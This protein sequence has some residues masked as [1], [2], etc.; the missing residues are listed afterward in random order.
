M[1]YNINLAN[2]SLLVT[3]EEGVADN[4][5]TSLTLLGKNYSGYG[6]SINENFV[7]LLENF[8][9]GT[10]PGGPLS[11]QIWY[12][13]TN[14][15]LKLWNG[16]EW[17]LAG[18][19]IQL[20]QQSSTLHYHAFVEQEYGAPPF[21]T[22]KNKGL[23]FQPSSGNFAINKSSIPAS[24]LEINGGTLTRGLPAPISVSAVG[25]T[26]VHIH[27]ADGMS[28]RTIIDSF[29]GTSNA[30]V[31]SV[32]HVRRSRGSSNVP[33]ALASSDIIGGIAS[34]GHNGSTYS[35]VSGA[36]LFVADAAWTPSSHPT[37]IDVILAPSNSTVA[38]KKFSFLPNGDFQAQG[39]VVAYNTS[40]ISLKT[41]IEPIT[42][43]F[44]KLTNLDGILFN[45]N[46]LATGK[47]T[48]QR[49]VGVI[50]QQVQAIMPEAVKLKDNGTLGVA[51]EKLIPLLI[52]AVKE[53]GQEVARLK[54]KI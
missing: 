44:T 11:G 36:M 39:D 38:T 21:R 10:A 16:L 5:T 8:A 14:Q 29:S 43:A 34:N 24:R 28:A 13:S 20:E 50:A 2:G 22:A 35:A 26:V 33:A 30:A 4:T 23:V 6:E 25:E 41:D 47:D 15:Q 53:L 31:T 45:W 49:E 42:G 51:Y 40:D 7:R 27:G 12:D 32:L 18:S 46:Q 17:T 9:R 19:G 54:N 1:A 48:A 52:E 37:R 3:I